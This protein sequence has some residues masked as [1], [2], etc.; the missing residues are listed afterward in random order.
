MNVRGSGRLL[1]AHDP[2]VVCVVLFE[3]STRLELL[4][5]AG[6]WLAESL[7]EDFR[8]ISASPLHSIGCPEADVLMT[9][10]EC[11]QADAKVL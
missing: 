1:L 5:P 8:K 4:P 10:R 6:D 2:E 7:S 9:Y 11:G 3:V